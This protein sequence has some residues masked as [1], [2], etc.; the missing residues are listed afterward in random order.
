MTLGVGIK[1]LWP[2]KLQLC[3]LKFTADFVLGAAI[4]VMNNLGKTTDTGLSSGIAKRAT[5]PNVHLDENTWLLG[6]TVGVPFFAGAVLGL[7]ITDPITGFLGFGRRGA[8]CVAGIFSLISVVGSA[9]VH[10]WEHLLGFRILL[11]AGMAGKASIVPILLSETSP[12]NVRGILLVFWQLF[13]AFGLAAGSVANL[14]VYRLDVDSS[15]RYM[16]IA[17]FLPA[18][19]LLSLILFSP[20]KFETRLDHGVPDADEYRITTLASE[21]EWSIQRA[22]WRHDAE[23][24]ACT[25]RLP[26]VGRSARRTQPNTSCW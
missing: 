14:S 25:K 4:E 16:F 19:L 9:S 18:L 7:I 11:G 24:K 26:I 3:A 1:Q 12:K 2:V 10:K 20:G 22:T 21:R 17:A 15:W 13:V 6:V 8:I 23:P 5:D